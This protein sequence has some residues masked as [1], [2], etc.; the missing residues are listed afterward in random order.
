MLL[1]R[2]NRIEADTSGQNAAQRA[3]IAGGLINAGGGDLSAGAK[4]GTAKS[5][6]TAFVGGKEATS[7]RQ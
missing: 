6:P 7:R 1:I 4:G 2:L 3:Q 5:L